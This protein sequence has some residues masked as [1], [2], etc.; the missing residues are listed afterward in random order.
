MNAVLHARTPD[1]THLARLSPTER[2]A[3][4][5]RVAFSMSNAIGD[6]LVCM[7][8]VRH[9]LLYGVD[10][11][12]FG[13]PANALRDWFP[14][15]TIRPML[16]EDEIAATF[17][18]FDTVIQMQWN[19]PLVSLVDAH[20]HVITLHDVEF[21]N[22]TGC[23]AHRFAEFCRVELGLPD[24][25]LD[26]GIQAPDGLVYRKHM[27]R[28]LIHPEAS[29][30]DKRWLAGRFFKLAARLRAR[31]YEPAFL[32]APHERDRWN[33]LARHHIDAP[34]FHDL[35][36][37]AAYVYESGWFI[38]NDSGMGHLASN[39]GVPTISL[40]RRRGSSERWSPA[41][42]TTRVVLPWQWVP[43]ARLKERF[44]RETLTLARVLD[45]FEHVQ[46]RDAARHGT[47]LGHE[48]RGVA[49]RPPN[50]IRES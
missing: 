40:F 6:S 49:S 43:S 18:P 34:L 22:R 31:G 28:V 13:K 42:G 7:I 11:T 32:I 46:R 23:M 24:V 19:Q 38:G 50:F 2:A 48:G 3:E 33:E 45:A 5:G 27:K 12:V 16:R 1:S 26:N 15:V 20:P 47:S 21:G 4:L 30:Q 9:L 29:T 41:W 39:L 10:V 14:G 44:W 36:E 25:S 37:L 17:A 35:G 8:I